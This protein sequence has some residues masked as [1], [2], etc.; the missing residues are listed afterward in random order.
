M[1]Y[2]KL[3]AYIL[4]RTN[5]L[6]AYDRVRANGGAPGVDGM[7][8]RELPAYLRANWSHIR[9]SLLD[10]SYRITPDWARRFAW[11]RK[12]GWALA[13]SPVMG[14]SVTEDRLRQKGYVPFLEYYLSVKYKDV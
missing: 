7:T 8:V 14:M 13:C 1:K 4:S 2:P 5:M 10:G 3:L 12:G 6:Q 9:Q 11:S